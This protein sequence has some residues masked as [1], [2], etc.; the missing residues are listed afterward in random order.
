MKIAHTHRNTSGVS[1]IEV[2][3]VVAIAAILTGIAIPAFNVF[4][5]N[6]RTSTIAN[7][8]VSALNLARSEAMKRGQDISICPKKT[9]ETDCDT[10]RDWNDGWLVI[11]EGDKTRIRLHDAYS[12]NSA[13]PVFVGEGDFEN[14]KLTYDHSGRLKSPTSIDE[15]ATY[16]QISNMDK[17]MCIYVNNSGRIRTSKNC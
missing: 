7:E 13:E 5:G 14:A 12:N 16:F 11:V 6:T 3:I 17:T 8:F 1:I 9:D 2:L 10:S 15:S 4:I